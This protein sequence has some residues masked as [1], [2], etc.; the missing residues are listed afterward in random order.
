ML[1]SL[2]ISPKMEVRMFGLGTENRK[3]S[4]KDLAEKFKALG[5]AHL[6][7]PMA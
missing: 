6:C 1:L 5:V 4:K 3:R 7:N 2:R